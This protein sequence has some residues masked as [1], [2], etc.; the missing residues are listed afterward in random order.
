MLPF[1]HDALSSLS[2]PGGTSPS[3]VYALSVVS[4]ALIV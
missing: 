2:I 4:L 1:P 3:G